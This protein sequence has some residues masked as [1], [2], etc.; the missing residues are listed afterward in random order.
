M[1]NIKSQKKR[2]RTSEEQRQRNVAERTRVKTIVKTASA[3]IAKGSAEE[4]TTAVRSAVS[5][6]DRACSKG[7]IPPNQAAR[8]K[9]SL[10]LRANEAAQSKES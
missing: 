2:I 7:I 10:M 9:S 5:A 4:R 8:R 1:A 3:T 6:I